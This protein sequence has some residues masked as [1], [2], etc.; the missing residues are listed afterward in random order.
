MSYISSNFGIARGDL[1]SLPEHLRSPV[2]S[3]GNAEIDW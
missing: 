2:V 1:V 3:T